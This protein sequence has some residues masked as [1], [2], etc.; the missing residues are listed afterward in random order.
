MVDTLCI[1]Y[2]SQGTNDTHGSRTVKTWPIIGIT[3]DGREVV[4]GMQ[5]APKGHKEVEAA[6]VRLIRLNVE[7]NREGYR[8]VYYAN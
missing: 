8:D 2:P 3:T 1:M 5:A 7:L 6:R 4:I